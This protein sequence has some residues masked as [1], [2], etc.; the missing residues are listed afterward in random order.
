MPLTYEGKAVHNINNCLPAVLTTYFF[1][2][3]TIEDIALA[4]KPLS[5]SESQ[6]P[7]RLNLFQFKNFT[8]LVDFAH[9]PHGL[10]CFAIL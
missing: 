7:G 5:L 6:T 1:R 2:D 3:I 9:N 10:N 4:C 8:I